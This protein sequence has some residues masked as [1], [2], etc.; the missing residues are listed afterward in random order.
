MSEFVRQQVNAGRIKPNDGT[1]ILTIY[2]RHLED[3][4]Y[5]NARNNT[6]V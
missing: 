4:T 3:T 2:N 1:R 6:T 5:C